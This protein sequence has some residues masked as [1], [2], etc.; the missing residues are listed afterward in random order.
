MKKLLSLTM[1]VSLVQLFAC[2]DDVNP[3]SKELRLLTAAPWSHASVTHA[4]DGDLSDQYKNFVISFSEKA[5]DGFDGTYIISN[6]GYAFPENSGTW[7]F[8]DDL[9]EIILDSGKG[10]QFDVEENT[11]HL[12]FSVAH[13]GGRVGGL[14]GHFIFDLKPL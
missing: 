14:S 6:G 1:L 3:K 9:D 12:D 4:T 8:N 2:D 11:L 13:P 5:G 7:K 10:M